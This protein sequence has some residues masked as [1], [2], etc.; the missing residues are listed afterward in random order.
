[1]DVAR[2]SR[3]VEEWDFFNDDDQ[4]EGRA[5]DTESFG[6]ELSGSTTSSLRSG[7]PSETSSL[8]SDE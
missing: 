4:Y 6:D 1:M 3:D 8:A 5:S 2:S 7:S